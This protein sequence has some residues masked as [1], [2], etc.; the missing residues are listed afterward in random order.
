ML[1]IW[2]ATASDNPTAADRVYE[3]IQARASILERF[4]EAGSERPG[5][6]AEARVL[7]EPPYLVL[8]RVVSDGVQ[9]VRVMHGARH[10]DNALFI[11]GIE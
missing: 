5:I 6:A 7:I 3:R 2:I 10:I 11:E 9:I 8:Y 1:D 4:P